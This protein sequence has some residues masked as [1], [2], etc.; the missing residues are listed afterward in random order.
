M[1]VKT[2]SSTY[3]DLSPLASFVSI[4]VG[5]AGCLRER[6]DVYSFG[7]ILLQVRKLVIVVDVFLSIP[8]STSGTVGM[9]PCSA[10]S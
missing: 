9:K 1:P 7:V 8:I 5:A 3:G 2:F 10:S 4:T 6:S